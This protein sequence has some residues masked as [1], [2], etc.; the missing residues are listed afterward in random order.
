MNDKKLVYFVIHLIPG[1]SELNRLV[2]GVW[3]TYEGAKI[4]FDKFKKDR[5]EFD[6]AIASY[7]VYEEGEHPF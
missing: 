2:H 1:H 4:A 7:P 5:P 3:S 6:C